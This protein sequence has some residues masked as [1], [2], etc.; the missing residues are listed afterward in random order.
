LEW[1]DRAVWRACPIVLFGGPA[2]QCTSSGGL[3]R[4]ISFYVIEVFSSLALPSN[5]AFLFFDVAL[6]SFHILNLFFFTF[7][8]KNS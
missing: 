6:E 4:G 3:G 5:S 1:F 2:R 7:V 8:Q